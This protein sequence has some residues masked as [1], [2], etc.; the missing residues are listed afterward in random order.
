MKLRGLRLERQP[1]LMIIPMIDVVFFLLVFFMVSTLYMIEQNV[2]PVAL[3]DA[4]SARAAEAVQVPVTLTAEGTIFVNREPV[5]PELL[6]A[7]IRAELSRDSGAG[8]VLRADRRAAYGQVV[9]I[10]D[11][12]KTAGV[13]RLSVATDLPPR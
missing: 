13:T 9:A 8:F 10:L 5:P 4:A 7:R 12:L 11:E 3:P 1:R 2:L 6:A